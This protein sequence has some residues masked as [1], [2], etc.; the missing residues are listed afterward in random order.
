LAYH[1]AWRRSELNQREYCEA[2]G[3]LL[4]ALGNWRPKFRAEPLPRKLRALL[5]LAVRRALRGRTVFQV[6]YA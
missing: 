6:T 1:E 2:E 5:V 4:K 3:I